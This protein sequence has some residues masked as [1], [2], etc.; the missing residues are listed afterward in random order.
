[1]NIEEF[2]WEIARIKKCECR[3]HSGSMASKR[4]REEVSEK[5]PKRI[6]LMDAEVMAELEA[7]LDESRKNQEAKEK[8]PV[9]PLHL[10]DEEEFDDD[11]EFM[12]EFGPPSPMTTKKR[13]FG[14][15]CCEGKLDEAK[16]MYRLGGM[17]EDAHAYAFWMVCNTPS[18]GTPKLLETAKWLWSLGKIVVAPYENPFLSA[19]YSGNL[20]LAQ[21]LWGLGIIT[22]EKMY[23]EDLFHDVCGSG[24]LDIAR[25]LWE[26]GDFKSQAT[27]AF[28]CACIRNHFDIVHW[29]MDLEGVDLRLHEAFVRVCEFGC[30]KAAKKMLALKGFDLSVCKEEAF[31]KACTRY[32]MRVAKWLWSLGITGLHANEE[33]IFRMVCSGM[34]FLMEQPSPTRILRM[35]QWLWGLDGKID[36]HAGGDE[37]FCKTCEVENIKVAKWLWKLD[38][39]ID[40]YAHNGEVF[41]HDH[42]E[43]DSPMSRWLGSLREMFPRDRPGQKDRLDQMDQL[44][45]MD[46]SDTLMTS[47]RPWPKTD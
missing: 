18:A 33:E 19:C 43:K 7:L 17:D 27:D 44:D 4:E 20:E 29:M 23:Q 1:M 35:A 46:P 9:S 22:L 34:Q 25:W 3:W 31:K 10:K 26:I 39:K 42:W 5:K 38:G 11:E 30:L 2:A 36:L 45:Q 8:E 40:L 41:E 6:R 16:E 47:W 15:L 32:Q 24:K 37:I 14:N 28:W 13:E 12:K 21:W